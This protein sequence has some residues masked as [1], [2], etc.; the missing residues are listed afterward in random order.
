MYTTANYSDIFMGDKP[1]LSILLKDIPS[2][3]VIN[4]LAIL[5]SELYLNGDKIQTQANLLKLIT[6]NFINSDRLELEEGLRILLK[7]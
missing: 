5:N 4:I 2:K 6:K 7:N 1:S 3:V